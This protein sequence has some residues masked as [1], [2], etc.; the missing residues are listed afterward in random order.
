MN[1][2]EHHLFRH[3]ATAE[4]GAGFRATREAGFVRI[5]PISEPARGWLKQ[6]VPETEDTSWLADDL[7]VE[8]RYF[9]ILADAIIAAGLMF[10]R[11]A[12][13]N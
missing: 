8:M 9:P 1:E 12:L 10:E 6:H 5:S 2:H 7:I 13:P 11:N 3:T 4:N